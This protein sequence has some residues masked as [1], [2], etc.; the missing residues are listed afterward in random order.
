MNKRSQQH[1][2]HR[3]SNNDQ[4]SA[5]NLDRLSTIVAANPKHVMLG[6]KQYTQGFPS[7]FHHLSCFRTCVCSGP[8]NFLHSYR[9]H[10]NPSL[11]DPLKHIRE[12]SSQPSQLSYL[13]YAK[14]HLGLQGTYAEDAV[15][16][17]FSLHSF[18]DIRRPSLRL[19][20]MLRHRSLVRTGTRTSPNSAMLLASKNPGR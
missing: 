7:L 4:C 10:I 14:I 5:T 6:P 1:C 17:Q 15:S 12:L 16:D 9:R 3:P 11:T 19:T 8:V 18:W 13:P 2:G 20:A